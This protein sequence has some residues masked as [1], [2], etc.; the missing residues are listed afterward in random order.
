MNQNSI[1]VISNRRHITLLPEDIL[2][3]QLIG[4]NSVI[5]VSGGKTYET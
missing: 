3:I 5:H 2:Y 4:R 1:S